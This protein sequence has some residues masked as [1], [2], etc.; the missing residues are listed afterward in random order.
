MCFSIA[1][2]GI[3]MD[4]D[5]LTSFLLDFGGSLWTSPK[6]SLMHPKLAASH[7]RPIGRYGIGF[8]SV[9]MLG[10]VV[11]VISKGYKQGDKCISALEFSKRRT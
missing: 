6:F 11:T 3:G 7:F 4:H 9:F 2:N 5:V 1:D 8:F 10:D